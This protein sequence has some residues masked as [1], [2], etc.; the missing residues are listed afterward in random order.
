MSW[1]SVVIP[2]AAAHAEALSDGLLAAGALSAE[3]GD[4]HAGESGETPIFDEPG[5]PAGQRVWQDSVVT[6]LFQRGVDVGGTV[7]RVAAGLGLPSVPAYRLA[8]IQEQDWVKLTQNQ[9]EPIRISTRLWIVPTWHTAPDA[10]A[11]N[12]VL[13]PGLAFG[14]GSHPTTRLCLRWLDDHLRGGELVLDYGCGSG[15]LAI[16]ALKLGAARVI[17]VD[18]DPQAVVAAHDNAA[19]NRVD[20]EFY[21]PEQAPAVAADIVVANIL[22]N[23]LRTLAPLL[24]QATRAGGHIVLSGILPAQA[25]A[26]RETYRAW[27]DMGAVIEEDGWICLSGTKR[28][29]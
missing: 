9:F 23:P 7:A 4:A 28:Q 20:A 26:V 12:I 21:L 29:A 22:A 27:F 1:L 15:I 5:E 18:I 17:G 11:I 8:E 10:Q 13:D 25:D 24:A 6:A 14:T 3:I 2:C 19:Q 16:A